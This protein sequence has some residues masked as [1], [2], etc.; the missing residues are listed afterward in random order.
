MDYLITLTQ[1]GE[2]WRYGII[3]TNLEINSLKM[4]SKLS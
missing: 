3:W 4:I 1:G 2:R